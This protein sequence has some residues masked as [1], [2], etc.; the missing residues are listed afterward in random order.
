M[1]SLGGKLASSQLG[2]HLLGILYLEADVVDPA[3]AA[4]PL[5]AR[6]LVVLEVKDRQ[7]DVAVTQ[8]VAGGVLGVQFL[9]LLETEDIDVEPGG[10][11][12]IL[13]GNSGCA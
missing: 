5:G 2:L 11:I 7:V 13:G 12:N 6:H 10:G 4:A 1:S 3:V 8:V 9:Y